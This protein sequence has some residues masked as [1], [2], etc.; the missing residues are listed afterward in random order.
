MRNAFLNDYRKLSGC[1][2]NAK[3][4]L[5]VAITALASL[6][7]KLIHNFNRQGNKVGSQGY[8]ISVVH[9]LLA[10]SKRC[11][12]SHDNVQK[13]SKNYSFKKGILRKDQKPPSEVQS[14]KH[15]S[16]SCHFSHQSYPF[17]LDDAEAATLCGGWFAVSPPL[18]ITSSKLLLPT[19]AFRGGG[20]SSIFGL[21]SSLSSSSVVSDS[22]WPC[23][24][25]SPCSGR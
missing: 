1:R 23:L 20:A 2:H 6:L 19:L 12:I 24:R 21:S 15:T 5:A 9:L 22:E 16:L 7:Q 3:S 11:N 17:P 4:A 18:I 25:R 13:R 14:K 8:L 10:C